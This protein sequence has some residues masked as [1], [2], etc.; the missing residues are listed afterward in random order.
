MKSLGNADIKKRSFG[1][2]LH[3]QSGESIIGFTQILLVSLIGNCTL[4]AIP[5]P[6]MPPIELEA[7]ATMIIGQSKLE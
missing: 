5:C 3:R 1:P 7:L 6:S 4:D 2:D